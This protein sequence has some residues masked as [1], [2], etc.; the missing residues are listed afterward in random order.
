[1][2][3]P[4]EHE[5]YVQA[6]GAAPDMTSAERPH[7]RETGVDEEVVGLLLAGEAS[8]P[9]SCFFRAANIRDAWPEH[10]SK[11]SVIILLAR[12]P[13]SA[14]TEIME[15][16]T[17]VAAQVRHPQLPDALAI[18]PPTDITD[19]YVYSYFRKPDWRNTF[20]V[21]KGVNGRV[22]A[23][24]LEVAKLLLAS[25]LTEGIALTKTAKQR[26]IESY[27]RG[28]TLSPE[29]SL[30]EKRLQDAGKLSESNPLLRILFSFSGPWAEE[31]AFT[32][33]CFL[34]S[35][36][37]G[38]Q[39]LANRTGGN[40]RTSSGKISILARPSW[41]AAFP[42]EAWRWEKAAEYML[43][44]GSVGALE[45]AR[46]DLPSWSG[47]QAAVNA[48]ASRRGLLPAAP[49]RGSIGNLQSIGAGDPMLLYEVPGR[50]YKIE[51]RFSRADQALSV[52]MRPGATGAEDFSRLVA[53]ST[54]L[55]APRPAD[56]YWR[57]FRGCSSTASRDLLPVSE[58]GF[59][60]HRKITWNVRREPTTL[61]LNLPEAIDAVLTR[62]T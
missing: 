8:A 20:Y 62:F 17:R 35:H 21:G 58:C 29:R 49:A 34:I 43:A 10:R 57:P 2:D 39:A 26:A 55:R 28:A 50:S 38:V 59:F 32:A 56:P 53:A 9:Q 11:L 51:M 46:L 15:A 13:Q 3:V 37:L 40:S 60:E 7:H 22:K 30:I 19:F 27:L 23:H 54:G 16:V 42:G 1:M 6:R 5:R 25:P 4:H 12:G 47:L 31:K 41:Y 48:M 45:Q 44:K 24:L 61:T 14:I 52:R 18:P 36:L 33:E